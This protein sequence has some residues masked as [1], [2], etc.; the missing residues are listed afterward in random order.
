M[1]LDY[2]IKFIKYY[3]TVTAAAFIKFQAKSE[4]K[5]IGSSIKSERSLLLHCQEML[6]KLTKQTVAAQ[7]QKSAA[8]S[9]ESEEVSRQMEV[10]R[11]RLAQ[12]RANSDTDDFRST[13]VLF[14]FSFSHMWPSMSK[15]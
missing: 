2:K 8:L 6:D 1:N 12:L 10:R 14:V 13:L 3:F 9:S 5:S 7:E 15:P 4:K 11:P